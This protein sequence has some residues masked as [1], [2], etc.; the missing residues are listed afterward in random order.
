MFSRGKIIKNV[1]YSCRK[2]KGLFMTCVFVVLHY[3]SFEMT[4]EC[5]DALIKLYV[6]THKIKIIIVDNGSLNGSGEQLLKQYEKNSA[7]EVILNEENVGFANGNNIGY[8]YAKKMY[9]PDYIVVMNNDVIIKD[10]E[11]VNKIEKI[12]QETPFYIM[13]PDI[14]NKEGK[15]QSPMSIHGYTRTQIEGIINV[16]SRRL[17]HYMLFYTKKWC[18]CRISECL[19]RKRVRV[20]QSLWKTQHEYPVIHGACIIF[21]HKYIKKEE[22][23][24]DRRTFLYFE[25]D[26]LQYLCKKKGY[27]LL[28]SPELQVFHMEDV[29]TNM[30]FRSNYKKMKMKYKHL[31]DSAS[32]MLNIMEEFENGT[33]ERQVRGR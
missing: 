12:Y 9:S 5:V 8:A 13:G 21:S 15:H 11:F 6:E 2:E 7:C 26:I 16:R 23:A 25:E 22:Y 33:N 27:L 31:I 32:V 30:A 14:V 10:K 18:R 29:S 4:M 24:F 20:D 3:L 28:Y 17:K 1:L 19:K